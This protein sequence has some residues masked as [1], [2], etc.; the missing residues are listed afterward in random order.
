MSFVTQMFS[1]LQG[2]ANMND[3][4]H[5]SNL[6]IH[7]FELYLLAEIQTVLNLLVCNTL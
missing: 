4:F 7:F 1:F 6:V 2:K 3:D 5:W